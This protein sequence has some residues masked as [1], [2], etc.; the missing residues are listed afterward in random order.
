MPVND[1]MRKLLV[2]TKQALDAFLSS[3]ATFRVVKTVAEDAAAAS[4]V[5]AKTL[6][7]LDSSFNPPQIAHLSLATSA[8][9][10]SRSKYPLPHRL[11][12]LFST[13]NADKSPAPAAF[14][15]RLAMMALFAQDLSRKLSTSGEHGRGEQ[16]AV[17]ID[18]G[19]TTKPYYNDKSAEIDDMGTYPGSPR[20]IHLVGF[21]TFTRIFAAKYYT[22]H[23]PPL[24]ALDP[25]F[26][27]H[28]LRITV[29]PVDDGGEYATAEAQRGYWRGIR[30]GKMEHE[31]GKATWA[32]KIEMVDAEDEAADVSSTRIRNAVGKQDWSELGKLCTPSVA[33]Y[34]KEQ[35]LYLGNESKS[36]SSLA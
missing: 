10:A 18:I 14:E 9:A 16:E 11:L 17:A 26:E 3:S 5:N 25:F 20:H 30:D 6:F 34:V 24:S 19:L 22:S 31:G 27:K 36:K 2:E 28:G 21:D 8:L 1:T 7:I 12:L 4:K 35:G 32:E 13:Y 15:H 29:R 23:S 33:E